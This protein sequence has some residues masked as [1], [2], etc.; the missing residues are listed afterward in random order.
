MLHLA[1][2]EEGMSSEDRV[3]QIRRKIS[4]DNR[5]PIC[6]APSVTELAMGGKLLV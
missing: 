3:I 5:P 1:L 2:Q 6:F 4:L